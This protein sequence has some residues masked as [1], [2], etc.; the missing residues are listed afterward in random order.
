MIFSW[1]TEKC[2][3]LFEAV[4]SELAFALVRCYFHELRYSKMEDKME[5]K[6]KAAHKR[7]QGEDGFEASN[8]KKRLKAAPKCN[9]YV[10][11]QTDSL[12]VLHLPQY[13]T[14]KLKQLFI[15]IKVCFTFLIEYF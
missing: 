14:E 7:S 6:I 5:D 8:E 12:L 1:L 10:Y 3:T 9:W 4:I 2:S 15:S 13:I 11:F